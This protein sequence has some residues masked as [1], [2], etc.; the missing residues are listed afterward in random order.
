MTYRFQFNDECLKEQVEY[1][2][3]CFISFIPCQDFLNNFHCSF[4]YC[5]FFTDFLLQSPNYF[6][7]HSLSFLL[8]LD[9]LLMIDC[10]FLNLLKKCKYYLHFTLL[11]FQ[12]NQILNHEHLFSCCFDYYLDA[13]THSS[14]FSQLA[15][16]SIL[17][18]SSRCH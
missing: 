15:H 7:F 12:R 14:F 9:Q 5:F 17:H 13:Q 16:S 2:L 18:H 10:H 1:Q 4:L 3:C 8:D 11:Y 6:C